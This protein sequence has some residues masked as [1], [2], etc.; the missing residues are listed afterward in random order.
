MKFSHLIFLGVALVSAIPYAIE[1]DSRS[2]EKR[3]LA[4]VSQGKVA[5]KKGSKGKKGKGAQKKGKGKKK[6]T[7][8]KGKGAKKA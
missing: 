4:P 2:L 8:K 3:E 6:K 5:G 7:Q 1:E